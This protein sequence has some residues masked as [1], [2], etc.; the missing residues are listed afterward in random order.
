MPKVNR[1]ATLLLVWHYCIDLTTVIAA[2]RRH[3][4]ILTFLLNL[5]SI[6]LFA[7]N[8]R[9]ETVY[10]IAAEK[11]DIF[12]CNVIEERERLLWSTTDR[13]GTC[14]PLPISYISEAYDFFKIHTIILSVVVEHARVNPRPRQPDTRLLNP[15]VDPP[16]YTPKPKDQVSLP[17][18]SVS[19]LQW[20]WLSKWTIYPRTNSNDEGWSFAQDWYVSEEEWISDMS[21]IP[22][23]QRSGIV[24]R[25]TWIRIMKKCTP[26]EIV[27]LASVNEAPQLPIPTRKPTRV[28]RSNSVGA[29]L[30]GL[31]V[32]TPSRTQHDPPTPSPPDFNFTDES[33]IDETFSTRAQSLNTPT[34]SLYETPEDQPQPLPQ[35]TES[36]EQ[37]VSSTYHASTQGHRHTS[38]STSVRSQRIPGSS[39]ILPVS[40]PRRRRGTSQSG[41]SG[42]DGNGYPGGHRAI[43]EPDDSVQMCRLCN[44]RFTAFLR[45]HHCR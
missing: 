29:R 35:P 8:L 6:D 11:A 22:P 5:S 36:P 4:E 30:L 21:S 39:Q 10:D 19:T 16:Q 45:R 37:T 33:E 17:Q 38:S 15:S 32:G 3:Y 31:V 23:P 42:N 12:M 18:S 7:R 43:W 27:N 41:G 40:Y 2:S 1:Q 9:N 14:F 28:S 44:R 24:A 34:S 25:R 20:A 26:E 13:E